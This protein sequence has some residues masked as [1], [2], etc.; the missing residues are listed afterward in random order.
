MTAPPASLR[1]DKWLWF[2]RL[3]K[4]RTEAADLAQTRRLR[5]DGKVVEKAAQPVRPGAIISFARGDRL[6][7]IRVLDLP[8]RRGPATV[9]R[10]FYETLSED[11]SYTDKAA[12]PE[13]NAVHDELLNTTR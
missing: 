7:V 13:T 2:T 9:A 11:L 8:A 12:M 1:I 4:T 6:V 10:L 3:C 5:I